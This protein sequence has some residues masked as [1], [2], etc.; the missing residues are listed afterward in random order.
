M[1]KVSTKITGSILTIICSGRFGIGSE[2]NSSAKFIQ[3][4]V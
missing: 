2:G 1:I 3:K 4:G